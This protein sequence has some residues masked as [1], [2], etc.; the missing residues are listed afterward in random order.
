M[1]GLGS[2]GWNL[3]HAGTVESQRR[4]NSGWLCKQGLFTE[5]TK[6]RITWS[7]NSGDQN[8]INVGFQQGLLILAYRWRCGSES[9]WEQVL[10]EIE[11][12][13]RANH[14]GGRTAYFVCPGCGTN[15]RYLYGAGERFK[16]RKCHRLTYATQR[17]RAHDRATRKNQKLRSR[18]KTDIGFEGAIIRP[19]GMHRKTFERLRNEIFE[20]EEIIAERMVE[21][22][23]RFQGPSK[24]R[25]NLGT[26]FWT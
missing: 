21:L 9:D 8:S 13:W 7:S 4:L 20:Q 11:L 16:C 15:R 12:R 5:G 2:G 19:K 6:A 23:Q 24:H 17:E 14:Y 3:K 18:L 1:G 26:Q 25:A 10:Q 22:V